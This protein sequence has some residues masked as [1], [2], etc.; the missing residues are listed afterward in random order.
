MA[1]NGLVRHQNPDYPDIRDYVEHVLG[2][3]HRP[4]AQDL[5]NAIKMSLGRA[6]TLIKE[7]WTAGDL[8]MISDELGLNPVLTLLHY[9]FYKPIAI[10]H[11]AQQFKEPLPE[12]EEEMKK[13]A[14]MIAFIQE[15]ARELRAIEEG[16]DEG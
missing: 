8:I 16:T 6:Q 9:K 11:A 7:G 14:K 13:Q 15:A 12:S 5:A 1:R 10:Q 4:T 3:E 2:P